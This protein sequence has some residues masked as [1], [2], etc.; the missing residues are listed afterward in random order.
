MH[1][2]YGLANGKVLEDRRM[3]AQYYKIDNSKNINGQRKIVRTPQFQ[4]SSNY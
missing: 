2:L 1:C 3:Y 4:G